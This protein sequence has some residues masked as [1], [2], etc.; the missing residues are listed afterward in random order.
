M[1]V[2]GRGIRHAWALD[3]SLV[4]LNH[5]T[6]G[7]PPRVV[8]AAQQALR[9][10]IERSPARFLLR[11][12]TGEQPAPWRRRSRLRE[13]IAPVAAFVGARADDMVFVT[14]VTTAVNAVLQSL[15]LVPGDEI[16]I[17]GL[18]YGAVALAAHATAR[19][20]GAV[21]RSV[22]LPL[23]PEAPGLVV[24]AIRDAL[25]PQTRLVVTDHITAMTALVLPV[26]DIVEVCHARG[27]PVL[28]DGA[29]AP[30][31]IDLDITALDA[32]WYAANLHKWAHAPRSCGFLWARADRQDALHHPIV[33]WGH[34]EGFLAEFENHAT[35]DPTCALAAP[36]GIALLHEWGWRS[37]VAYLHATAWDASR[38]LIERWQVAL[39]TPPQMVGA[40]VTVPLPEPAGTTA[41]EAAALRLA[42]L[43][44]DGI[45]VQLHEAEG[46][47]WA[48]V[49]TQVYNDL[50][51]V[52]RLA[53]AVSRRLTF[54]R[55]PGPES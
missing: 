14:N 9:D 2:F 51:D 12:L 40:M 54:A 13:A 33:S 3:P 15:P 22:A 43:E 34:G 45:E 32:D 36:A 42:L 53:E 25:T 52:E 46:R 1:P 11:E 35:S 31:A 44:E 37:V 38:L 6:V 21:V 29:H 48:R 16:V 19:R 49:S 20:H 39:P 41:G 7:A 18:A 4:Y 5:G 27:V 30:G 10:E 28:V 8:L 26:A 17:T 50:Q 55:S 47:L 23:T 24:D